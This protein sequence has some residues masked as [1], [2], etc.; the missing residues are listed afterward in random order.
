[1][2]PDKNNV[3]SPLNRLYPRMSPMIDAKNSP[4]INTLFLLLFEFFFIVKSNMLQEY[5]NRVEVVTST[6]RYDVPV[7]T[8]VDILLALYRSNVDF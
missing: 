4:L 1:M 5:E 8:R 7:T 2:S 6:K 3:L